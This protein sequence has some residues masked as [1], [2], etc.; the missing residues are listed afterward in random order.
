VK[1][2]TFINLF[3]I[4]TYII[5]GI[6]TKYLEKIKENKIKQ[7]DTSYFTIEKNKKW[8]NTI[9]I[10]FNYKEETNLVYLFLIIKSFIL[11][12]C[13]L[14]LSV[15]LSFKSENDKINIS[16]NVKI[17]VIKKMDYIDFEEWIVYRISKEHLYKRDDEFTSIL[18]SFEK[19]FLDLYQKKKNEDDLLLDLKPI[20]P[21]N[22]HALIILKESD[23]ILYYKE[24]IKTLE[25]LLKINSRHTNG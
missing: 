5:P 15:S 17:R 25:E 23:K 1:Q 10:K 22:E 20:F 21:W 7:N 6:L 9:E 8:N 16:D 3:N 2:K 14:P 24:K 4:Y 18:I 19:S 12:D 11:E 13:L